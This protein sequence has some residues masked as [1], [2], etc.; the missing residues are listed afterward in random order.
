VH[1]SI[2]NIRSI[3]CER[4]THASFHENPPSELLVFLFSLFFSV[5]TVFGMKRRIYLGLKLEMEFTPQKDALRRTEKLWDFMGWHNH[6]RIEIILHPNYGCQKVERPTRTSSKFKVGNSK[7]KSTHQILI[8][9]RKKLKS[10]VSWRQGK[11]LWRTHYKFSS[12][13]RAGLF[14]SN[15]NLNSIRRS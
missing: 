10:V 12:T 5:Y 3:I 2:W 1:L 15:L 11:R 4:N 7:F 9:T 6:K 14:H 13:L 8:Q